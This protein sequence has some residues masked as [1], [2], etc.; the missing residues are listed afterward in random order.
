MHTE[1]PDS[2][3]KKYPSLTF[4]PCKV[5]LDFFIRQRL[6]HKLLRITAAYARC[7]GVNSYTHSTNIGI[8]GLGVHKQLRNLAALRRGLKCHC[9]SCPTAAIYHELS[10]I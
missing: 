8:L 6:L 4:P 3:A 10:G 1:D 7:A 5:R 2:S 9:T